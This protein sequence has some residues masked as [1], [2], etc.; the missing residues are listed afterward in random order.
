MNKIPAFLPLGLLLAGSAVLAQP[1]QLTPAPERISDQ[2]IHADYAAYEQLQTRIHQL[3]EQGLPVRNY[4]LS[5]AQC[6]LDV[7]LH[8]Y[9]RN[10]RSAFP[11]ASM[12]ESEKLIVALENKTTPL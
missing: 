2:A 8:E 6:W 3:N 1:A 7:S 11:Q 4:H 10:D 12:T 5:K 9:T